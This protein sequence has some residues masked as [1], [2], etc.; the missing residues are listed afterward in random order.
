MSISVYAL[1]G[2]LFGTDPVPQGAVRATIKT[3]YV[4]T[5][6]RTARQLAHRPVY[7]VAADVTLRRGDG[8]RFQIG[9]RFACGTSSESVE[10]I[11]DVSA[12][13]V[14]S[15]CERRAPSGPDEWVVYGYF[16]AAD[17]PL[18]VGQTINLERRHRT[19]RSAKTSAS[20]FPR[21]ADLRVLD[22]LRSRREAL[23]VE[24]RW[25]RQL[26]PPFNIQRNRSQF[27]VLNADLPDSSRPPCAC[28]LDL[29]CQLHDKATA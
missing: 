20:W 29:G 18:Y 3:D 7:A 9:A 19:H 10:P 26:D 16:D 8:S 22:R 21:V 4:V 12:V 1:N 24:Q 11:A 17:R 27:H 5:T 15:S 28:H 2:H 6:H 13:R 25:I 14:C 23:D